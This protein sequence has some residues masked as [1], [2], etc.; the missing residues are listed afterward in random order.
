ML[1]I[2][3]GVAIRER[4]IMLEVQHER[5][6]KATGEGRYKGLPSVQ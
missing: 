2:L 5:I 4:E 1:T 6:A 3:A